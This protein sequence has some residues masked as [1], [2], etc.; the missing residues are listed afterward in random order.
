MNENVYQRYL[1]TSVYT[2]IGMYKEFVLSLPDDIPSIGMLICDQITHPSMYF[3]EPSSYL[4]DT[5]FGKFASYPKHRFKNE[6]E[7]YITAVS[8]IAGI[9][10]LDE[11]GFT[12]KRDVTKRITVSCRQASVLFSAILKAKGIP[13]RSRAGFMD[14]GDLGESYMEHW[15]NEYWDFNENRWVLADVDGYYEY[16]QRFGYSQFDLPRRKFVTASE[17]WLGLR[18]NTLNKKL[19]VFSPNPLEGV[20][21]YL[22]M[23]F[24]ALMNNEIFYSYQPLYLRGGI[25]ALDENQLC[26]LDYLA[27]LLA[28]PDKNMEQIEH[29][30]HTNEEFTVLTN[31]TQNI[32]YDT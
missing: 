18:N 14:F 15:V 28:E 30:W 9:L 26:E 21:E 31:N 6:D 5:Y 32:Y 1:E 8:M 7:L 20:C 24:H 10:R 19:D 4:E 27:E 13:C 16:E 22:F 25:Q 11:T 2:Y 17:A 3:T 12:K 29:L 23:D